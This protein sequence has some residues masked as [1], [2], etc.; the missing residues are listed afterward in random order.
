[1]VP[2]TPVVVTDTF[3]DEIADESRGIEICQTTLEAACAVKGDG[4]H[5]STVEAVIKIKLTHEASP[6]K[7]LP[8]LALQRHCVVH[9]ALPASFVAISVPALAMTSKDL[10]DGRHQAAVA[11]NVSVDLGG[12]APAENL[13]GPTVLGGDE[14]DLLE[15][16]PVEIGAD[17]VSTGDIDREV[18][19]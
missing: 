6:F 14:A 10:N 15:A 11:N 12:R 9:A 5:Q 7:P 18:R 13:A 1:V 2:E 19:A 4:R 16:N 17:P 8:K 3:G